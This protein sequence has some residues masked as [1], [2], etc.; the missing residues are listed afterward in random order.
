[1]IC[2]YIKIKQEP[3]QNLNENIWIDILINIEAKTNVYIYIKL[4]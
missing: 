1:M 4:K 2:I 3:I